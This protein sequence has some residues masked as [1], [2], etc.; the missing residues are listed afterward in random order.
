MIMWAPGLR[1]IDRCRRGL[2]GHPRLRGA[3][4]RVCAA[5]LLSACGSC[6]LLGGSSGTSREQALAEPAT[7][8]APAAITVR[9]RADAGLNPAEGQAHTV[10]VGVLQSAR[11]DTLHALADRPGRLDEALAGGPLPDGVLRLSRYV[12]YPG[13]TCMLRVDRAQKVRAIALAAGYAQGADTTTLRIFD[14]PLI[15]HSKGWIWPSYTAAAG[16]L[17]L[18]MRLGARQILDASLLAA[19]PS[20]SRAQ[21]QAQVQVRID[22]CPRISPP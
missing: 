4:R 5:L 15:V 13:A 16:P 1:R 21:A 7:D 18:R 11:A 3:A 20:S 14:I 12:V 8:F 22:D 10:V 2:C 19:P 17:H 6:S 9:I